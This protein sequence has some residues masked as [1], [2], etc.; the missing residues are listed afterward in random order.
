MKTGQAAAGEPTVE[1]HSAT[2]FCGPD[3]IGS[4]PGDVDLGGIIDE[5]TKHL[6]GTGNEV[7]V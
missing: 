2:R 3:G 4:G 5:V 1:V 7:T 6:G